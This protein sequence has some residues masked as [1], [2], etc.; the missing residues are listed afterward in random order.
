M[1]GCRRRE[2]RNRLRRTYDLQPAMISKSARPTPW[3][4]DYAGRAR[5]YLHIV[6]KLTGY[7]ELS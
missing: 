1:L 4:W 3:S 5:Q 7:G 2:D 6:V